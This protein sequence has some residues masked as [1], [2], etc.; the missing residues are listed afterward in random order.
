[1]IGNKK[2]FIDQINS[3]KAYKMTCLYHY[4]GV[5]FKKAI[6]N[7][8]IFRRSDN[9]MVGVLQWGC[10]AQ[11]K[12]KLD[13]YV[14]EPIKT[15]EYLELN[16]FCMAD[17]E[18]ANAE[19]QAISLGIKWIKKYRPDIRLLV[20]YAGRKEGNY[21][22]IYQAT[23]WEYLGY[24]I[25]P[26]F[27]SVDGHEKHLIT[28]WCNYDRHK[29]GEEGF[30]E[31]LM[32]VYQDVRQTWTKQFIY[33][34]RLDNTLTP[35]S[36]ILPYPKPANEYP[37]KIKEKILKQ[38]DEIY[39]NPLP[40][41]RKYVEYYYEK[42]KYLFSKATLKRRGEIKTPLKIVMYNCFGEL[43]KEYNNIKEIDSNE[44]KK[45][46]INKALKNNIIYKNK[47]F[48]YY[49]E[50]EEID[51]EIEVPFVCLVDDMP[52]PTYVQAA[53]YLGVSK[54]A[55]HQAGQRKAKKVAGKEVT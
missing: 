17:S 40:I 43:E 8:G 10:S 20:S 39:S 1:M 32:R 21:G 35:A 48:K 6:L 18:G 30:N 12:I 42:D 3:S 9:L 13:R 44:Y 28:L 38:N 7:L 34:Q 24:F 49:Y 54:Q 37:I 11:S 45:E 29:E 27:W 47:Y 26:G 46:G 25:S 33:I 23:N 19:S 22:Y 53:A 15:E 14:K 41:E 55:V 5:G 31:H 4:S 2:Y 36:D 16:R 50:N 52:F 51:Q